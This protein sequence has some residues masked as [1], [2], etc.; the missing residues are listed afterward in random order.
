MVIVEHS[1]IQTET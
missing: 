1:L